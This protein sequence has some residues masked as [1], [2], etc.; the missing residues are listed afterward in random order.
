MIGFNWIY[1]YCIISE[2]KLEARANEYGQERERENSMFAYSLGL[3]DS[4]STMPHRGIALPLALLLLV[5]D[6]SS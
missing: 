5:M 3:F 1:F 2:L 6:N 4:G